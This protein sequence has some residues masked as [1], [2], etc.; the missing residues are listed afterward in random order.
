MSNNSKIKIQKM[1]YHT[2]MSGLTSIECHIHKMTVS[3]ENYD[4][5]IIER[6]Y[7]YDHMDVYVVLSTK[8]QINTIDTFSYDESSGSIKINGKAYQ[9]Y[10]LDCSFAYA[11]FDN[12]VQNDL[13]VNT[14]NAMANILQK[15]I[16]N[17]INKQYR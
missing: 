15:A 14:Y 13:H 8:D 7:D 3:Y 9:I 10:G 17:Y 16:L 4:R 1:S 11:G 12:E 5:R 2:H 6:K